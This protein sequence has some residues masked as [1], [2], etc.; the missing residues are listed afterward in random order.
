MA[1][2]SLAKANLRLLN[3][4]WAVRISAIQ[5]QTRDFDRGHAL[6][7]SRL[8]EVTTSPI[9]IQYLS[10]LCVFLTAT[11][12]FH[13]KMVNAVS[14]T[15]DNTAE[16]WCDSSRKICV[17]RRLVESALLRK[18]ATGRTAMDATLAMNDELSAVA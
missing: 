6:H 12:K 14:K 10:F 16:T 5:T 8:A 1:N 11:I 15:Q 18:V 13:R 17:R 9:A 3:T 7:R 4:F 2:Q